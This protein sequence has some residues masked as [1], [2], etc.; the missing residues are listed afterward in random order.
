MKSKAKLSFSVF[1]KDDLFI[2]NICVYDYY[3][4]I[5]NNL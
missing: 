3:T 2:I 1:L 4:I 5:L